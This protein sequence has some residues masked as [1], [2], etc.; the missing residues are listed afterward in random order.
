M[1]LAVR[2]IWISEL[3]ARIGKSAST[4]RKLYSRVWATE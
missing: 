3:D 4:S 1:S 2:S